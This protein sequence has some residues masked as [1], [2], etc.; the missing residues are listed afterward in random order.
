MDR[1]IPP[2]SG[3][4]RFVKEGYGEG[5]KGGMGMMPGRKGGISLVGRYCHIYG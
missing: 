4:T 1:I 5:G 3:F 2:F